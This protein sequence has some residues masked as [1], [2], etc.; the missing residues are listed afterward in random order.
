METDTLREFLALAEKRSYTATADALFI[1]PSALSRHIAALETQLGVELFHR[2][3]RSVIVSRHGKILLPFAQKLVQAEDEYL[4]MLD[5]TKRVEGNGLRIG[6]FFGMANHGIMSQIVGFL[7]RNQ[8]IAL[9]I[10]SEEQEGLLEQLKSDEYDFVFVQENG[11]S[12]GDEFSRLT[13]AMDRLVAVLPQDHLLADAKSIRLTQLR[14][15]EFLLQPAQSMTYRLMLDAFRRAEYS[16]KRV[17]LD[18]KGLGVVEMVEQGLGIA[19]AQEKVAQANL[20]P[21]VVLVPLEPQERIWINMVWR[22]D[23]LSAAGKALI[24]YFRDLM[25]GK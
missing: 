19:L 14:K 15:E 24:S 22:A 11:P 17:Q 4:E 20:L 8:D 7:R 16:P 25:A 6:A 9:S 2:N 23:T 13:V 21:G 3:S 18:V 12:P 1:S 10:Q 5:K